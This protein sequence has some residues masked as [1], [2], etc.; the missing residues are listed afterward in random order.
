MIITFC[1]LVLYTAVQPY[2]TPGLSKTQTCSL[3]AQFISLYAGMCLV[4]DSYVQKD[5]VSA[6]QSDSATAQTS[7]VFGFLIVAVNLIICAWPVIMVVMSEEFSAQIDVLSKKL[8]KLLKLNQANGQDIA[9]LESNLNRPRINPA[10]GDAELQ[11][12]V[13]TV[14]HNQCSLCLFFKPISIQTSNFPFQC[15]A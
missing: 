9:H 4:I 12:L 7:D 6:G 1:F 8:Q 15:N 2:C 11:P 14:L 5:L 13:E 10:I 3:I